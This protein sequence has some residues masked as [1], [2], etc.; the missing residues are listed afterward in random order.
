MRLV[1]ELDSKIEIF[2]EY[3][4]QVETLVKQGN[5]LD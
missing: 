3:T 5:N 1:T 2:R 4:N